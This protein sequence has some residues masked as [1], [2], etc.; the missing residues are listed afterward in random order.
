M[1]NNNKNCFVAKK[2]YS[3]FFEKKKENNIRPNFKSVGICFFLSSDNVKRD[4][5]VHARFFEEPFTF[6]FIA[7]PTV[8]LFVCF[9]VPICCQCF[10]MI[11]AKSKTIEGKEDSETRMA[12][13]FDDDRIS[14]LRV[15]TIDRAEGQGSDDETN[16]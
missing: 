11:T 12:L 6:R 10:N 13:T 7:R 8:F 5:P 14:R 16:G 2:A 9:L 15:E 4:N 1:S 3:I